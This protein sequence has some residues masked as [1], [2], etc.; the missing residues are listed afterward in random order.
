MYAW[1]SLHFSL[2]DEKLSIR[3][4]SGIELAMPCQKIPI[5]PIPPILQFHGSSH[6][7]PGHSGFGYFK[8]EWSTSRTLD[9]EAI[10]AINISH[11]ASLS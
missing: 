8:L 7:G 1:V 4:T 10:E 6:S 3:L 11:T 9:F 2:V 5:L